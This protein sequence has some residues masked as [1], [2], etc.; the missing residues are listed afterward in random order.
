MIVGIAAVVLIAVAV[1]AGIHHA[2]NDGAI[3]HWR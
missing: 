2:I 3:N 1:F